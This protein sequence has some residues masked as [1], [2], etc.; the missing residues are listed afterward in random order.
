MN[1]IE[2]DAVHYI[3]IYEDGTFIHYYS[4]DT[5]EAAEKANWRL[6]ED[7]KGTKIFFS[8]WKSYGVHKTSGCSN[9]AL[10]VFLKEGELLFGKTDHKER[11]FVKQ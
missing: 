5:L 1:A 10:S 4:K 2:K 3:D 8:K 9:C 7:K 11:N 6:L